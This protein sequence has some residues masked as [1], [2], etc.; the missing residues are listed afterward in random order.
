MMALQVKGLHP[1]VVVRSAL[2]SLCVCCDPCT[3]LAEPPVANHE[4]VLAMQPAGYWPADEGAGVVLH[5][6]SANAGHGTIHHVPWRDGMLDF[7][8]GFQ[9]CEVPFSAAWK[10]EGLTIGGWLF[11]REQDYRR[12]GMLFM[13]LANPLRLSIGGTFS[14]L[15]LRLRRGIEIEIVSDGT[16]DALGSLAKSDTV[17][18]NEWQH[19]LYTWEN[20]SG[21]LYLNGAFVRSDSHIPFQFRE[22]PLIVGSD[23]RWWCLHP[24]GSRSLTGSVRGLVIFN[25]ALSPAEIDLLQKSTRPHE[26]PWIASLNAIVIGGHEVPLHALPQA[27]IA[28]Q[29]QMM[30]D[31]AER[32]AKV[33][34]EMAP[35]LRDSLS[36]MLGPW[37][38]RA[39]AAE[40]LLKLDR[41]RNIPL[42]EQ[43]VAHWIA[44]IS[45][46]NAPD[47]DRAASALALA[48]MRAEARPAVGAL[49]GTLQAI[50]ERDGGHP[51]RVED[52]LRNAVLRA[53]LD[54]APRDKDVRML[55]GEALGQ[56]VLELVDTSSPPMEA[57]R[58][59]MADGRYADAL[60]GFASL[61]PRGRHGRRY[62]TQGDANRDARGNSTAR[63]YTPIVTQAGATYTLGAGISFNGVE[64]VPSDEFRQRVGAIAKR[65]PEAQNW[66]DPEFPHLYR[67]RITKTLPDGAEQTTFLGGEDFI[68]D[69]SDAKIRGW[70]VAI[71]N[72]GY[73]HVVG[74]QHNRPNP[75]AYV[76]GS[77]E[78]FGLSRDR[79]SEGFPRQMYFVSVRPNDPTAFEFVGQRNNARHI[80]TDYL[81]YMNW[82]QDL[83]GELFL[84]GRTNVS[85][86]QSWGLYHYRAQERQWQ[87][88]GG[89]ACDIISDAIMAHPEWEGYLHHHVRGKT[90]TTPEQKCVVWA[91]QPNFYNYCRDAWGIW[92]DRANRMHLRMTIRGVDEHGRIEDQQVYAWSDDLGKTF[93][94]ADGSPVALPL[95]INPAPSHE[96]SAVCYRQKIYWDAYTELLSRIGF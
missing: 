12:D 83:R 62:F 25:R 59:A 38:T 96:A 64:P 85:G 61:Q 49:S 55:I 19:V 18:A 66:R 52:L 22:F 8:G 70:S 87:P 14:S 24:P 33:L 45:D 44:C 91:W 30:T 90:P 41:D 89:D 88:L 13:G 21:K 54:I 79:E 23:A 67:V 57:I 31:L 16:V 95:T 46:R 20:G 68:F 77:W 27:G 60:F 2:I 74:G 50:I 53:L 93:H 4:A 37:P 9:W 5:D 40:L 11:T 17:R 63:A 34:R 6:L 48:A 58:S 56:P 47:E 28:T 43:H 69:G 32:D 7:T 10:G 94:R 72:A 39:L 75:D 36:D 42:L 29:F 80:P 1:R 65:F 81:N 82:V 78:K 51:P 76:P 35:S 73:I 84:Y 15:L 26:R 71:D 92:F 86:W 3:A